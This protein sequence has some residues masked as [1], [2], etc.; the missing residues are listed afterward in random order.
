MKLELLS[1]LRCPQCGERLQ[2]ASNVGS[3]SDVVEGTLE[4]TGPNHHQYPIRN[5]T[6]RFVPPDN[7]ATNFGFQW[8]KFRLT[9][10]D[11]HSGTTITRDR[12]FASTG[13][14]PAEMKGKRVLDV[15]CGAG[16][17]AEIALQTGAEV[18]ALD[19]SSAVDACWQNN[20]EKGSLHCVQGDIYH[21]PFAKF[22]FDFVYCLGVLQ[23]TPDV[24]AAFIALTSQTKP[25]GSLAIDVYPRMWQNL[26][27]GKDW[28]RPITKRMD[29]M[30][31]FRLVENYLVPILLPVSFFL[32]RVPVVGRK[33][34][35]LIPVSNYEGT[36]P[37]KRE[38]LREWAILD[39]YDMLA[40]TYDQPQTAK[41]VS[42]WFQ[43]SGFTEVEVFRAGHLV[44]RGRK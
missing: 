19:F 33:L 10:L 15:G 21:L 7:Y 36:F 11:S 38:Q 5:S 14:D 34:R 30:K 6:P 29:R 8:N 27:S 4:C 32:G 25:G 18:V 9:Q 42:E 22:S 24:D 2:L 44:G 31:L 26:A 37:L 40:P 23:H 43:A 16:R 35:H 12:F 20:R 39:T 17:F 41:T 13:W 1:I 28:I 3:A